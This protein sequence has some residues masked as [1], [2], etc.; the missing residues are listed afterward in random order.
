MT[1]P[2]EESKKGHQLNYNQEIIKRVEN[3]EE[4]G[5]KK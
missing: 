2:I 5:L 4:M 1:T 3:F